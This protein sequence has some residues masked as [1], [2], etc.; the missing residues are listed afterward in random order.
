MSRGRQNSKFFT[1]L[2]PDTRFPARCCLRQHTGSRPVARSFC[3]S[4]YETSVLWSKTLNQNDS[5]PMPTLG[6]LEPLAEPEA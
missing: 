3:K 1:T 4:H 6:N 2:W 5:D